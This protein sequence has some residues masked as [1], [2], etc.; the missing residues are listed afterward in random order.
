M[1]QHQ[2]IC[3]NTQWKLRVTVQRLTEEQVLACQAP[4]VMVTTQPDDPNSLESGDLLENADILESHAALHS[5]PIRGQ[6]KCSFAECTLVFSSSEEWKEHRKLHFPSKQF[7]CDFC[8]TLFTSKGK[9][10]VHI[11]LHTPFRPHACEVPGC[12]FRGKFVKDLLKHEG[13]EH[14]SIVYP[15]LLCG[16]IIKRR[17]NYKSHVA[18]HNTNKPGVF[19]CLHRR[20]KKLFKSSDNLSKHTKRV[21]EFQC[22]E[23]GKRLTTKALVRSHLVWHMDERMFLCD[24]QGCSYSTKTNQALQRHKIN[25]HSLNRRTARN[26]FKSEVNQHQ[27]DKA[28]VYKCQHGDCQ[29]TFSAEFDL[30][31]H[32]KHHRGL[33]ECH[34]PDCL[35]YC[36]S[37]QELKEHRKT[38]HPIWLFNCHVCGRGFDQSIN[39]NRHVK[40]HGTRK[41]PETKSKQSI[42]RTEL[43]KHLENLNKKTSNAA[44]STGHEC[45]FCGK[46]LT[47]AH[48][49]KHILTHVTETPGVLKCSFQSCKLTFSS[50]AD[51]KE[52]AVPMHW[53]LSLPRKRPSFACDVPECDLAFKTQKLLTNHKSSKHDS[54]TCLICGQQLKSSLSSK[55]H[56]REVHEIYPCT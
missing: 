56:M 13:K 33:Y 24:S 52:H 45:H 2:R 48:L 1:Q 41:T 51:L 43:K 12:S 29:E 35:F 39:F 50:A 23:C 18:R 21:H 15:C 49:P 44:T 22:N 31:R 47:K 34:V 3:V 11:Q 7:W 37:L 6:I 30:T 26:M 36:K 38:L 32:M 28:V 27:P 8:G 4:V 10:K 42:S 20:C 16:K 46:I 54:W 53:D 14:T 40:S 17:Q 55:R 19:K 9:L 5:T 25:K